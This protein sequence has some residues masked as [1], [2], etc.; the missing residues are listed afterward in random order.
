MN[1]FG[2]IQIVQY[3]VGIV[4]LVCFILVLV[5]IFQGGQTGLG[6]ACIVLFFCAAIG[7][8]IAFIVGWMNAARWAIRNIMILWTACL[9]LNIVLGFIGY[10]TAGPVVALG[11]PR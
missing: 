10:A 8:L 1:L 5:R 2:P 4:N 11:L 9:I 3:L 6:V 7:V